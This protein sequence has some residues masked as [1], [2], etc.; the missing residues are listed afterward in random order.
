MGIVIFGS[1]GN[2]YFAVY[3]E[4]NKVH[5]VTG[6]DLDDSETTD[7]LGFIKEVEGFDP[8]IVINLVGS[9]KDNVNSLLE[10]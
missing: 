8:E 10:T 5:E 4:L 2:I 6:V 1:A 3:E 7:I 9:K